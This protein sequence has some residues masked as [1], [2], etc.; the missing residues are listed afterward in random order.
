MEEEKEKKAAQGIGT[1]IIF[2]AMILVAAVAAGVLIQTAASLQSKSL[3][4][5]K[6]TQ[7]KITTDL[8]VIQVYGANAT[9]G[10]LDGGNDTLTVVI[11]LGTGSTPIK[12][13][14]TSIKLDSMSSIDSSNYIYFDGAYSESKYNYTYVIQ[15]PNAVDG[16]VTPGDTISVRF[17]L[18]TGIR[19][20]ESQS[21]TI[22]VI[23]KNGAI[24]PVD[25]TMPSASIYPVVHLYP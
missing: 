1:L 5:G 2:I 19:I 13:S 10:T 7:E 12:L 20:H 11:R 3:D 17:I 14:E 22:R 6:Q 9:D 23:P 24:K 15:G 25:M 21:L 16:Y 8:E 18:K 4:V